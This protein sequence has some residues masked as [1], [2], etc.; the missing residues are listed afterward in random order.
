[1]QDSGPIKSAISSIRSLSEYK[2]LPQN[3]MTMWQEAYTELGGMERAA[4]R[5][6]NDSWARQIGNERRNL[7]AALVDANPRYG[8][9]L[10]AYS[11]PQQLIDAANKGKEVFSAN[12]RPDEVGM[13]YSKMPADQRKEFLGGV[14]EWLRAKVGNT[15]RANPA[16]RIW[17]SA[18]NRDRMKQIL[19][20][21]DYAK[22]D[23]IME[24]EK[25]VAGVAREVTR[26]SRTVPMAAEA[27][28][29][30]HQTGAALGLIHKVMDGHYGLAALD[31]LRMGAR[32]VARA[33]AGNR[34]EATNAK[35]AEWLTETDPSKVG[36]VR[37]LAANAQ[38]EEAARRLAGQQMFTYGSLAPAIG[39]IQ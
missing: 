8:R 12:M 33:F 23:A 39:P 27:A 21:D 14:A 18:N 34:M 32:P 15:D 4:I 24:Q 17:N 1:M 20:P 31:L 19:S 2:Y 16:E 9:A 36:L 28:D 35:L 11:E 38:A 6:G 26:G 7:K 5:A 25:K 30:A 13:L 37:S 10:D 29:T 3:S 22:F